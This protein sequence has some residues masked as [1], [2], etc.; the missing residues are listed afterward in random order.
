MSSAFQVFLDEHDDFTE[1]LLL[2]QEALVRGDLEP[3]RDRIV[4][5]ARY[6]ESGVRE[7]WIVDPESRSV[8]VFVL[9]I[10]VDAPA[11]WFTGSA[12][13][14]TPSLPDLDLP[15]SQVFSR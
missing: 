6:A 2:H 14:L 3:A 9:D 1:S 15:L 4:K 7:Y 10:D 13:V 8:E 12:R 5:L 11:G